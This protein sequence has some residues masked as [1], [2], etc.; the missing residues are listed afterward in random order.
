MQIG[1]LARAAGVNIQTIRFYERERLLPAPP[2]TLSGYRDYSQH[3]LDRILFIRRNHEIGFTLAEVS[4]LLDL[5]GALETLPRPLRRKTTQVKEIIAIGRERL[6]QINE[7][8]CALQMMKRQL[9]FVVRHLEQSV[10]TTCP[11][12]ARDAN[13]ASPDLSRRKRARIRAGPVKPDGPRRE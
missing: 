10:P 5:H 13:V 2:R 3:H 6:G 7:K 11:V 1:E 9:E 12:A 4:Q 8:I